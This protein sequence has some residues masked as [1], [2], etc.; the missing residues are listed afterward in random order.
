MKIFLDDVRQPEDCL[1]YMYTR[2][3]NSNFLYLKEWMIAKNYEDFRNLIDKHKG[4]ITH[5]SF[6]HDLA[7]EHYD[8]SMFEN[9]LHYNNLYNEF[10]EKTGLDC[11]KYFKEVYDKESLPYPMLM[12][13]TQNP[14]GLKN[15]IN[16][17]Q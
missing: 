16:L 3:G 6:D 7:H 4:N 8:A 14:V 1:T 2:V 17:F 12:I 11:A 5:I 13:H 15:L 10:K 9:E